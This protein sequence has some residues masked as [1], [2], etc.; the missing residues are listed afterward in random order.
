MASPQIGDMAPDF[1]VLNQEEKTFKLS[2]FRGQKVI[3]FFYPEDDTP[4]CTLE[5][6]NLRDNYD[7]LLKKGYEVI[8]V[9][10]DD[11]SSHARFA[12]KYVLPFNLA[13]DVD[14]K[15]VKDYEVYGLKEHDGLK[16]FGIRRTTFLIAE[17]GKIEKIFN[18]VDNRNHTEQILNS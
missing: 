13:A 17:D 7:D 16:Y 12:T 3:L 4:G 10:N 5:A 11:A 6:C 18:E 14:K 15:I 1:S 2:D 9:S 8:G